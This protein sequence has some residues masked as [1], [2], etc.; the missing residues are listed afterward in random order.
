MSSR[1]EYQHNTREQV[2]EYIGTAREI[3]DELEIPDELRQA[4]FIKAIDLISA[5][6]LV[7]AAPAPLAAG[8]NLDHLRRQ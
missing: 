7:L 2:L 8:M 4:A 3:V 5:K 6:Q 1:Q